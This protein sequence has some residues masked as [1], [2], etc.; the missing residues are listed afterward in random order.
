MDVKGI[1][2]S[3]IINFYNKNSNKVTAKEAVKKVSD[4]IEI[5]SVGKSIKDFSLEG[6]NISNPSKIAELKRKVEAGTYNV[7]ARLTANSLINYIKES[8][9]K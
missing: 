5:S 6:L 3:N 8:K 7:D 1:G 9:I 4:T 2:S